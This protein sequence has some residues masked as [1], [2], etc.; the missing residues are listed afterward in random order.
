MKFKFVL[1]AGL[2]LAIMMTGAASATDTLCEEIASEDSDA[3]E[4]GQTNIYAATETGSFNDLE[5]DINGSGNVL[6]VEMDYKFNN[7]TDNSAG[8]LISRDNFILNGNGRTIDGNNQ[9]RIF[10]ITGNNVTLNNLILINGNADKG[11][12]IYS[13]GTLKLNNVTFIN[14]YATKEGGAIG[15]YGNAS[16]DCDNSRFTDNY[17]EVASSIYV[18]KYCMLNLY[19]SN[20]SSKIFNKYSQIAAFFSSTVYVENVTFINSTSSYAPAV[21]LEQSVFSIINSRF[22]NLKANITAGAIGAKS[23]TTLQVKNCE[24]INTSS[25]KNG[26]AIYAAFGS[27]H[28]GGNMAIIDT[29][30]RDTSSGFGG[31]VLQLAGYLL[32]NNSEFMNTHATYNGG[33]VYISRGLCEIFNCAF[34]SNAVE[35]IEGYPTYGGAIYGDSLTELN[36]YDSKFF[37]NQAGAGSAISL[38]DAQVYQIK[39]SLFEN[40][41]NPIYT[42]FDRESNIDKSNVFINNDNISTNNTYFK[43]IVVGEGLQLT[44]LNNTINVTNIPSRFDLRDWGWVSP[45]RNQ[46][47]GD[48]CWTFGMIGALESALLKAA[49]ITTDLSEIN[50][51]NT[52]SMYSI[53]GDLATDA[54]GPNTVSSSYLLS[55]LGAFSEDEDPYDEMGKISPIIITEQ[56]IHVQDVMFIPNNEV[57]NGT[58]LKLAIMKYGS[59]DVNY[60]SSTRGSIYFNEDTYAQYLD[61]DMT[62][63]HEVTIVGWDDNFPK[64][65]FLV[66]PPGDGAWIVKNSWGSEWCDN[67][68]LYLSYYDKSFLPNIHNALEGYAVAIIIENTEPYN[69]NYQY[70]MDWRGDFLPSNGTASYMNVFEAIDDDLIAAV[71]TYFNQS[72]VDYTVEIFVNDELKLTQTGVSPYLGYHTI[73]LNDYIPIKKGDIFKAKITSNT[74]PAIEISLVRVH[75]RENL[76]FISEDGVNWKDAYNEEMISI[77]KVYTVA[78]DRHNTTLIAPDRTIGVNDAIYGYDYQFIL[79]DENGTALANKEVKVSFNGK[80]Q[81]VTTDENGQATATLKANAE[82][83]YNVEMTFEGDNDYRETNQNATIT[84]KKQKTGIYAQSKETNSKEMSNG[85]TYTAILKDNNGKPIENRE[86]LFIFDGK[87]QTAKTD[88]NGKATVTLKTSKTGLQTITIKF[89]GDN[90]YQET[91]TTKTITIKSNIVK[92]N[93][94]KHENK[95]VDNTIPAAKETLKTTGN[96]IFALLLMLMTIGIATIRRF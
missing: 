25:S 27:E 57:P 51:Q 52:M 68:Y 50:M 92:D 59:L 80:T 95:T 84:L 55:W 69:K 13:T 77:L 39:D 24:F 18:E 37:N 62:P 72:D 26:G 91:S 61:R 34:D 90:A 48:T 7:G 85:Y 12:A 79:K 67:G 14:N 6:D 65:K 74:I 89:K 49:G 17:A 22:I 78:D 70:N 15:L 94:T 30:F 41:T 81:T 53:Y 3:L 33:S 87:E 19:N 64:E 9:S 4:I 93:S 10:N 76:S 63:D 75:Y 71:G 42:F 35:L 44:L 58:Q 56:N 20:L 23:N 88:K 8:I 36:I 2:I 86:I 82:G 38:Y 46:G 21:Y 73:K 29:V 31:A 43:T 11:G 45:V 5:K 66:T 32:L 16:L 83:N 47:W 28:S 1:I 54:G 60:F 96:P 40:N